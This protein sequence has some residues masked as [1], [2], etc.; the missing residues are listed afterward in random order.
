[1]GRWAQ[2]R[3][4][5][6]GNASATAAVPPPAPGD[7]DLFGVGEGT[8]YEATLTGNVCVLPAEGWLL[9]YRVA[10]SEVWID[11]GSIPNGCDVTPVFDGTASEIE[12]RIRW[13]DVGGL[14]I[15]DWSAIKTQP[16]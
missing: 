8:D 12:A 16:H 15:S 9:Q 10:P 6:R 4:R 5:G 14:P 11:V 7:W 2:A 13:T 1:M 3:H